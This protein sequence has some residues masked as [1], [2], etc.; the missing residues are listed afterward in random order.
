MALIQLLTMP[1][2]PRM[3]MNSAPTTTQLMKWGRYMTV[4]S[5]RLVMVAADLVDHQGQYDAGSGS[6]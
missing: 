6:R 2:V 1:V 4:C 3:F 5:T